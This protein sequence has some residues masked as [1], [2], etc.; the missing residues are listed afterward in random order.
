MR[1]LLVEDDQLIGDGIKVGLTHQGHTVN[2]LTDGFV[3]DNILKVE[4]FDVVVL[5]LG[6]PNVSGLD[7]LKHLRKRKNKV[8]VLIL[9]A[10]DAISD[11]IQGLDYGADDYLV[12]P[13]D[14]EELSARLRAL[15]RRATDRI[16]TVINY[17]GLTLNLASRAVTFNNQVFNLPRRE[18]ALLQKLLENQGRALSRDVLTQSMYD[19]DDDVDSNALEVHVHGLRKKFGAKFIR[20]IRGVGYIVEK[21]AD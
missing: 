2:W 18:F 1:I 6:L 20:T 21:E 17:K 15:Q 14:L 4:Q 10:W 9:T 5:D 11:R 7:I 16:D 13:F 19:W 8:P 3:A 12:K